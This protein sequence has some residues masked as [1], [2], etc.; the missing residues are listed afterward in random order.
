[1]WAITA[2]NLKH[3]LL[4]ALRNFYLPLLLSALLGAIATTSFILAITHTEVANVVAIIASAP[5][6][7]AAF[8]QVFIGERASIRT[9]L[10]IFGVVIGILV[11]VT[12]SLSRGGILGDLLA[13]LAIVAFA[14]NLTIWRKYPNLSRSLVVA[15]TS[16]FTVLI[17]STPA[18]PSMLHRS[19]F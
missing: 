2:R 10:A 18:N 6:F 3:E 12:G 15:L 11:I 14:T 13:L 19:A 5:L 8:A 9:W 17:T 4:R 7:A 1:M 16:T